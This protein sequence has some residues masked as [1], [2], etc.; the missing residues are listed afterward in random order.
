MKVA[1]FVHEAKIEVGHTR[2]MTE[3]LNRLPWS[4]NDVLD[5]ISFEFNEKDHAFPDFKGQLNYIKIPGA[6]IR[7]FFLKMIYYHFISF[8]L[9]LLKYKSY[10]KISIGLASFG[11]DYINI[12]FVHQMWNKFY[13]QT[14]RLNFL[15]YI[16]KKALFTYFNVAESIYYKN[17][18]VKLICLSDF[19]YDYCKKEFN[20]SDDNIFRVYSGITTEKFTAPVK[21]KDLLLKELSNK[22]P[23]LNKISPEKPIFLFVGAFERKGIEFALS[24]LQKLEEYQIIIVGKPE[25]G[26]SID[27]FFKESENIA[28]ISYTQE[29]E[30]FYQVSD[31]FLFPT[32]YEPFGLVIIEAAATG[33]E[34]YV[35]K[36]QVGASEILDNLDGIH[37]IGTKEEFKIHPKKLS[38]SQMQEY[39]KKRKTRFEMYSWNKA[40]DSWLKIIS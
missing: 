13:F 25:K 16:Y 18:S 22:Y 39:T 9:I 40:A 1:L 6:N 2:A 24:S 17:S 31:I 35:T 4:P 37:F 8:I 5:V 29:I 36:N 38:S 7:P 12:Q 27:R 14:Q 28:Y 19:I 11:C 26:Q 30:K 20:K 34:V 15:S 33:L 21:E 10:K 23:E 32:I 3:V